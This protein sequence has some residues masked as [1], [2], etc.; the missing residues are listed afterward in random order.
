M[1]LWEL[2]RLWEV[3]PEMITWPVAAI[4]CIPFVVYCFKNYK[5]WAKEQ[6][7]LTRDSAIEAT[8][9][10]F[11]RDAR[12][13]QLLASDDKAPSDWFELGQLAFQDNDRQSYFQYIKKSAELS[14]SPAYKELSSAFIYGW[15]TVKNLRE[16]MAWLLRSAESGD[17][18]SMYDVATAYIEGSGLQC[19]PL[20][21]IAWLY[22]AEFK[23]HKKAAEKIK[24]AEAALDAHLILLVQD[25]AKAVA[26]LISI[27]HS[28][29][30]T[31]IVP[32]I[33]RPPVHT[34]GVT[35]PHSGNHRQLKG[36]GTGS[37]ISPSGFILTAAHVVEDSEYLEV[38]TSEGK[39]LASVLS[40]DA[41]N[42]VALIKVERTFSNT[43]P[44]GRSGEVRLGASVSTI[45]FPNIDIQ[46][47]SPKVTKGLIS[48]ENGFQNDVRLWQ[49]SVPVQPGNSGG[50][51]LDQK[52]RVVGIVVSQLNCHQA[53]EATGSIPQ[54]VNYAIKA[55]YF[56]PLLHFH[57]VDIANSYQ[58]E[59]ADFQEMVAR[60]Q[61]SVVL[62][63]VY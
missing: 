33:N 38:V 49:I 19:N 59:P 1:E 13:R 54:N 26:E 44:L 11:E 23:G 4:M 36:S 32:P 46:G 58:D 17:L 29:I 7:T 10:V 22:V 27:G 52:G 20:E 24:E 28:T 51:L 34:P 60:S 6:E 39:F 8:R 43:I 18:N 3:N 41:T 50:P 61:N 47:L 55:S 42:D 15:G 5:R 35:M 25:R 63:L 14:Y 2:K 57:K 12:R 48:G 9:R 37:V 21:G 31:V 45:G 56:E 40:L 16:S 62:I 53:M 30:D